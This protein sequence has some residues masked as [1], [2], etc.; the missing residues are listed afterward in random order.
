MRRNATKLTQS[1]ALLTEL[2]AARGDG[3]AAESPHP[4]FETLLAYAADELETAEEAQIRAHLR[5]C[6]ACPRLLLELDAYYRREDRRHRAARSASSIRR[7]AAIPAPVASAPA[8]A[9]ARPRPAASWN[10]GRAAAGG[11]TAVLLAVLSL[12][13]LMVAASVSATM[14]RD[15]VRANQ[16]PAGVEL[17][18][19]PRERGVDAQRV[20]IA[21]KRAVLT[22]DDLQARAPAI[23]D[24]AIYRPALPPDK[25]ERLIWSGAIAAPPDA[26]PLCLE[27]PR[28]FL[29]PALYRFVITTRL[30]GETLQ[31][32]QYRIAI[33]L[34]S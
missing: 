9:G 28:T 22:F 15:P 29:P 10:P 33:R 20:A 26:Q 12:T 16:T 19:I 25:R 27:L 13:T 7:E 14:L 11:L 2:G 24:V 23:Y 6:F 8:V 34:A 1:L 31:S 30:A 5:T 4:D 18:R 21:G 3:A 32:D 17:I